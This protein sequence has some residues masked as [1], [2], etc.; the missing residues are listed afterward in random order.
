AYVVPLSADRAPPPAAAPR[1][2]GHAR[3]RG[4]RRPIPGQRRGGIH[5][6]GGASCGRPVDRRIGEPNGLVLQRPGRRRAPGTEARA[7]Q[8]QTLHAAL[9]LAGLAAASDA[10]GCRTHALLYRQVSEVGY[11]RIAGPWACAYLV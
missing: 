8:V 7:K 4:G 3:G 10:A 2:D 1:T 9:P 5:Y 6:G 11:G